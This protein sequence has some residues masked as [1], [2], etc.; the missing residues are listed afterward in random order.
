[1]PPPNGHGILFTV[2]SSPAAGP[3][4]IVMLQL[5]SEAFTL[6]ALNEVSLHAK[7][8]KDMMKNLAFFAVLGA[9]LLCSASSDIRIE[10]ET[11]TGNFKLS[12]I[13]HLSGGKNAGKWQE[14]SGSVDIPEDGTWSIWIRCS[15][16]WKYYLR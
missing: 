5:M 16:A 14:L 6:P 15:A 11:L 8:R 10:A 3:K 1:M 12:S 7:F 2:P 4:I 13:K 9:S